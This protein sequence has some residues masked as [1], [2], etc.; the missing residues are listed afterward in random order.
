M[1]EK[2]L[3]IKNLMIRNKKGFVLIISIMILVTLLLVGLYLIVVSQTE[4]KISSVQSIATQ[5]YYLAETGINEMIWKIQN[6]ETTRTAFLNGTLSSIND[7]SRTNIFSDNKA[8]Y[9]VSALSTALAEA[10]LIAT[11]TYQIQDRQSQRVVKAYIIKA[12]GSDSDWE[13]NTFSGGKGSNQNGNITIEGNPLAV[14]ING[15]RLHANQ[16]VK[17]KKGETIVNDGMVTASNNIIIS[18]GGILTLNNSIKEAPTS[19]VDMP[20]IDFDSDLPTSWKNRATQIYTPSQFEDLPSG[21]SLTGIIYVSGRTEWVE[22]DLTINGVLVI[23]DE[24]NIELDGN[25][26]SITNNPIYGGGIL[27]KYDLDINLGDSST[28]ITDGLIYSNKELTINLTD[29]SDSVTINGAIIGWD[30][31]IDTSGGDMIVNFIPQYFSNVIDPNINQD[32]PIIQIDHWE[33]QY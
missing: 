25:T 2:L 4:H 27:V 7:I 22:K 10:Q 23:T 31:R 11:S 6:D 29:F 28:L 19:T 14:T 17:I 18:A 12:T 21:T 13:Y 1:I 5:T 9:K 33:E 20:Q 8:S 3:S 16:D 32:S 24:L 26:F 15:G 30:T